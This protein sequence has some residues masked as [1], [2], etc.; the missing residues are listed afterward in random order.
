M[1]LG[2]CASAQLRADKKKKVVNHTFFCYAHFDTAFTHTDLYA[3]A[4]THTLMTLHT[5]GEGKVA[6]VKR[7]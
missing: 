3:H 5:A 1:F 7:K 4:R 2:V 6:S